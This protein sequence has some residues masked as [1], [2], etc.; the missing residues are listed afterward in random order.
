M[1]NGVG[2]SADPLWLSVRTM[3]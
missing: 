1:Y 3:Y 2:I